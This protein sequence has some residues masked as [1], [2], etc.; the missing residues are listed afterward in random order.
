MD[1]ETTVSYRL[2][3]DLDELDDYP[4]TVNDSAKFYSLGE[5]TLNRKWLRSKVNE[6]PE[7]V[8]KTRHNV[9]CFHAKDGI[10]LFPKGT[11]NEETAKENKQTAD[12]LVKDSPKGREA[13]ELET[14]TKEKPKRA[15]TR[16]KAGHPSPSS[17]KA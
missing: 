6:L 13:K 11:A 15:I 16:R 14:I 4:L 5:L 17:G 3:K 7:V 10:I 8:I 2:I 12:V 1:E 9:V